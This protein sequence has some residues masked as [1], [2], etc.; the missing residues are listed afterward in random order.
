[1]IPDPGAGQLYRN[2]AVRKRSGYCAV[3]L[4]VRRCPI[5]FVHGTELERWAHSFVDQLEGQLDV[6]P[7]RDTTVAKLIAGNQPGWTAKCL[8]PLA[9]RLDA[10]VGKAGASRPLRRF[11]SVAESSGGQEPISGQVDEDQ[12]VPG[13]LVERNPPDMQEHTNL[14]GGEISL[15]QIVLDPQRNV[16]KIVQNLI[17]IGEMGRPHRLGRGHATTPAGCLINPDISS[18][19]RSDS[20]PSC[21]PSASGVISSQPT[22]RAPAS[23]NS[24]CSL[25]ISFGVPTW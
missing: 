2:I 8:A 12:L 13:G 1:V 6:Q 3:L 5:L 20:R 25:A 11:A 7:V 24:E 9:P 4:V 19:R 15:A 16:W 14:F 17:G 23:T 10:L 21:G 22:N 18:A